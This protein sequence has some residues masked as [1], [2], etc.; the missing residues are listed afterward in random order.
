MHECEKKELRNAL[1]AKNEKRRER[2]RRGTNCSRSPHERAKDGREAMSREGRT[3]WSIECR[4]FFRRA[5]S[6]CRWW[7]GRLCDG[8]RGRRRSRRRKEACARREVRGRAVDVSGVEK[9]K[10][11]SVLTCE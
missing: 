1:G 7:R 8:R 3:R 2:I 6:L 4:A 5:R 11:R 9:V 10:I